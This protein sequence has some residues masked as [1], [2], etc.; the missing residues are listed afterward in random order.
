MVLCQE[1]DY[2]LLD[3]PLNNLDIAHSVR[4]MR[5]LRRAAEDLGRTI[6]IV[7]H[8]INFASAYSD[9]ICCVKDGAIARFGSPA[10]IMQDDVL[11]EIFGTDI[12]V[13]RTEG[14]KPVAVYF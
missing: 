7:M 6:I 10:E 4:M 11:S 3:E 8:D 14:R 5:H 2:V 12:T 13:V 9:Y 1:T